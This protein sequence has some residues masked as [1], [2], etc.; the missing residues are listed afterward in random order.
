MLSVL[1]PKGLSVCSLDLSGS[2]RSEGEYISLGHYEQQDV[3]AVV[4]HLRSAGVSAVGLWGRS[5]GAATSVLRAAEDWEL[6]ALVLDSPFSSLPVVAQELVNSQIAI[7][8]FLVSMALSTVRKEIQQRANFDIEQLVPVER[9]P[10]ARSPALFATATD[11]DFVLPHH[12]YDLLNAWNGKRKLITFEGGHNGARPKWFLEE[13]AEFLQAHLEAMSGR[14]EKDPSSVGESISSAFD[15]PF[16]APMILSPTSKAA[17]PR[18]A[19]PKVPPV[20]KAPS[21]AP[22]SA[23]Q[24]AIVSQL[25]AM[26]VSQDIAEEAAKNSSSVEAAVEWTFQQAAKRAKESAHAL[27][28]LKGKLRAPDSRKQN[29]AGT[30]SSEVEEATAAASRAL[31]TSLS[32]M[33]VLSELTGIGSGRAAGYAVKEATRPPETG[34]GRSSQEH[35]VISRLTQ[36][37]FPQKQAEEAA[38]R[39]STVEGAVDWLIQSE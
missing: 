13:G 12:T 39:C 11:D 30:V 3:K 14:A 32:G 37:G 29:A 2:G 9:A 23:E 34:T 7:P 28:Q 21:S 35:S 27:G 31:R 22:R 20:P 36:L 4:Q 10:Q 18:V 1:L 6:A 19:A 24:A 8:D 38:R 15:E 25:V 17:A 33:P 26:G 5:M 16:P